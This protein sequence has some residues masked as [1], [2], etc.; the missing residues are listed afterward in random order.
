[1]QKFGNTKGKT[2]EFFG[3]LYEITYLLRINYLIFI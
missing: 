1:M 3:D 2:K